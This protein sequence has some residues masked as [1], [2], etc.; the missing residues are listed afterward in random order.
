[1]RSSAF[2]SRRFGAPRHKLNKIDSI[3]S[4][5]L[6]LG[7]GCSSGLEAAETSVLL[8]ANRTIGRAFTSIEQHDFSGWKGL[9]ALQTTGPQQAVGKG[10]GNKRKSHNRITRREFSENLRA[11][12]PS[13]AVRRIN[14]RHG[15]GKQLNQLTVKVAQER[16]SCRISGYRHASNEKSGKDHDPGERCVTPDPS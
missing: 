4:A 13:A 14:R 11:G 9:K 7:V 6:P 8:C 3:D 5:N 12:A 2:S 16:A 15:S 1:M 10:R